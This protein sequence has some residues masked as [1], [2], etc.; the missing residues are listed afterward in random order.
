MSAQK[1]QPQINLI[2]QKNFEQ[3]TTGRV[4]AWILSTFRVIVIVTEIIVMVAFLSRFWLDAKNSDLNDEINDKK[5]VLVAS[6]N[7]EKEFKD[8]QARLSIFSKITSSEKAPGM[9]LTTV[10]SYLPDDVYLTNFVYSKD[11]IN[12]EGSSPSETSI[13]QFLTNI[14]ASGK[15]KEVNLDK[16]ESDTKDDVLLNFGASAQIEAPQEG[17]DK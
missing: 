15:F 10:T 3:T 7:F 9:S 2:P 17:S 5:A 12:L 16:L 14:A 8:T 4:L 1:P 11:K 6:S 13:Q